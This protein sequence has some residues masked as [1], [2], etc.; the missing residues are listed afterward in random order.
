MRGKNPCDI[1]KEVSR[2]K[3]DIQSFAPN[4]RRGADARVL[5]QGTPKVLMG[6][7]EFGIRLKSL[8]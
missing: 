3:F 8:K 5:G 7:R 4:V 6:T 2:G 1:V